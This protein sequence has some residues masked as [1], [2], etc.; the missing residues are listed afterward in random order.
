MR[1]GEGNGNE[2]CIKKKKTGIP[3]ALNHVNPVVSIPESDAESDAVFDVFRN[4]ALR[5]VHN[6]ISRTER[7]LLDRKLFGPI[8]E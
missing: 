4:L 7:G 3:G 8:D 2:E 5:F 1:S 6:I